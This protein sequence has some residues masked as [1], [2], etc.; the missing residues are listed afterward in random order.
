ME[1][2]ERKY[3][4]IN[5]E[6]RK[7]IERLLKN[8]TPKR[9]IARMLG[10]SIT[11]I[12]K[13]I[14]RGSVEQREK[15][16]TTSK[17]PNIPLYKTKQVYFADVGQRDYKANR[18]NCGCKCKI[19]D[20]HDFVEYVEK[21]VQNEKWSLDAAAGYAKVHGLYNNTC[22]TKTLYNWVDMGLCR[23]RNI[24]L[25]QR[26][27]RNP[28]KRKVRKS[29]RILG[30]SIELR[31]AVINDRVEFGHWE[32][33]GIVGKNKKG[34]LITLVE[35]QT[36]IGI[37]VNVKDKQSDK[38]VSVVDNLENLYGSEFPKIFKSITFDNGL[39]FADCQN[40]EKNGR[41]KVYYAHPYSSWERGTNENWNGIVRR[42]I[43]KGSS[44]DN[45]KDE[46]V[47]RIM[48]FINNLPRKRFHY[49]SPNEMFAEA[50]EKLG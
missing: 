9:Q 31:P 8:N 1:K 18:A 10:R 7:V 3:H 35:R 30:T 5:F 42:F 48:N 41:T 13:E 29:K 50:L 2:V 27:R 34:H 40:I 6:E 19:V 23:I 32:G 43:P 46:D 33:D 45:L 37:L 39:E 14:K 4:Q 49:K 25:P 36:D 16:Y 44:F 38:I 28:H 22:S 24:D 17:N 20:C 11:T 21:M 26:I 12:R 47:E 15:I